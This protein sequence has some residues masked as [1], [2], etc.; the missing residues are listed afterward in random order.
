MKDEYYYKNKLSILIEEFLEYETKEESPFGWVSEN[1]SKLMAD[2]AYS[3]LQA[4]YEVN[5]YLEKEQLLK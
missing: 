5:K 2:A 3:V 4:N 1:L